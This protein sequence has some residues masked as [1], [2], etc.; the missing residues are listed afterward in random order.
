[1]K[2]SSINKTGPFS[3]LARSSIFRGVVVAATVALAGL[4]SSVLAND[5]ARN[6][7]SYPAQACNWPDTNALEAVVPIVG[8]DGSYASGVVINH[9]R[10]LTAAHAL[11]PSHRVY[12]HIGGEYRQARVMLL[13][14]REDLAMLSVDTLGIVPLPVA[15]ADPL[16]DEPVWAVGYPRAKAKETTPGKLTRNAAGSLHASASIDLGQSGGGL[17]LCSNGSYIL[18]GMLRGYGAYVRGDEF[19]KLKNHSVSVGAST[20]QRF[21]D[22]VPQRTTFSA[23]MVTR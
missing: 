5:S 7:A 15:A 17:L 22:A 4:T 16:A 11:S 10:V 1:M 13:D 8:E 6:L 12:V 2:S 18:G 23:A 19:V 3:K 9:N 20:I 14:R 21:F